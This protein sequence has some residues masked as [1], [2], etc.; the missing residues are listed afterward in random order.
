MWLALLILTSVVWVALYAIITIPAYHFGVVERFGKRTGRILREGFNLVIPFVDRVEVVTME[1]AKIDVEVTLT[2]FDDLHLRCTGSLQYQPDPEISDRDGRNIF[3]TMSEEIIKSGIEEAIQSKLGGLGGVRTGEDFIR[4]R[5]AFSDLINIL[6]RVQTPPHFNHGIDDEGCIQRFTWTNE[7]GREVPCP[8]KHARVRARDLIGYYNAHW[9]EAKGLLDTEGKRPDDRSEI[10]SRYGID[11]KVFALA[12]V[13]FTAETRDAR[14]EKR[15]AELRARILDTKIAAMTRIKE[16]TGA[17]AQQMI[18]EADLIFHPE[19][20][21][22]KQIV[23]VQGEFPV[24]P[25]KHLDGG[26]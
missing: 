6:L 3:V 11:I 16:A 26:K 7:E 22:K 4:F 21:A 20:A 5:Q 23:S 1:L 25:I 8:S 13:E 9:E 19:V 10:E 17:N 24:L 15:Q 14:E 18:D 12:N 2:T